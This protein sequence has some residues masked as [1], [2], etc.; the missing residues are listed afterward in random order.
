MYDTGATMLL[1]YMCEADAHVALEEVCCCLLTVSGARECQ[2]ASSRGVTGLTQVQKST[3]ADGTFPSLC[4]RKLC[5]LDLLTFKGQDVQVKLKPDPAEVHNARDVRHLQ[6][7]LTSAG[8]GEHCHS[9]TPRM[10]LHTEAGKSAADM[11]PGVPLFCAKYHVIY[12]G[13]DDVRTSLFMLQLQPMLSSQAM[14]NPRE[15][16]VSYVPAYLCR[17]DLDAALGSII[18]ASA[19]EVA[20]TRMQYNAAKQQLAAAQQAVR[21]HISRLGMSSLSAPA[22]AQ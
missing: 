7:L 3:L 18:P 12:N 10:Q 2:T 19:D 4:V 11:Q 6:Q 20:R 8:P 15:V 17:Q 22:Q 16:Q 5:V 13:E 1:G 21:P 9:R 14:P